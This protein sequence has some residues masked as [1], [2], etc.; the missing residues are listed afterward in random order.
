LWP[1]LQHRFPLL[2]RF[3][4]KIVVGSIHGQTLNLA[5]LARRVII[6]ALNTAE[7]TGEGMLRWRGWHA[8]R[9][10]LA[11]NFHALGVDLKVIQA[12]LG[13]YVQVF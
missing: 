4:K 3:W 7:D 11:S 9:R 12:T 8:F 5:N 13:L 6:S 1:E 2:Q 10:S